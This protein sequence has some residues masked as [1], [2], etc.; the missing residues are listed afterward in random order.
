M[1]QYIVSV[2][3]IT[4]N[5]S[6]YIA[7]AIESVLLQKTKFDFEIVIGDDCSTD[8][9]KSI[10]ES[11]ELKYPQ[12]I[13]PVYHT[14]NVG[15]KRNAYEFTL[16]R[17][18]GKYIA[19]LEGDDYWTDPYKLQ[20]QVD[21]LEEN[22]GIVLCFSNTDIFSE[23]KKMLSKW[24]V[25]LYDR[26]YYPEEILTDLVIPTCSAVFRNLTFEVLVRRITNPDY[27][28]GD[29][30][31][32]LTLADYGK[33]Y[34]I[35]QSMSVYRKNESSMAYSLGIERVIKLCQQHEAISLDFDG[36]Y[37]KFENRLLSRQYFILAIK[38]LVNL[39]R[40]ALLYLKKSIRKR[41]NQIFYN[42]LYLVGRLFSS[43]R[44]I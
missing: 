4:F 22:S 25:R 37:M 15:A 9:T 5:Q 10:I 7:Q 27:L 1:S 31:L 11:Y 40:R 28:F 44:N 23:K 3:M 21:F 18:Q 24:P 33:L 36:K 32:W 17:C 20:K 14:I 41:P 16:P 2:W 26:L 39:D 19:C 35:N 13:H 38:L 30:I 8:G 29:M 42:M 34:C 43:N 12:V 6:K